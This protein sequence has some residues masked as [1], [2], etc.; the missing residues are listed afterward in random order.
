M[1]MLVRGCMQAF[2]W[3]SNRIL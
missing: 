1:M 2:D 3:Q